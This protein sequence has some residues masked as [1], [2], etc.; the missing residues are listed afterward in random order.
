MNEVPEVI[1]ETEMPMM[2][3]VWS[4]VDPGITRTTIE[5]PNDNTGADTQILA[6]V[7]EIEAPTLIGAP[8]LIAGAI[9]HLY[10]PWFLPWR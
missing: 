9:L 5:V 6:S 7:A 2:L 1:D 10:L 8:E 4:M 3:S